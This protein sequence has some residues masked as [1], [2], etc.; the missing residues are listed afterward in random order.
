MN[1]LKHL[2]SAPSQ[3]AVDDIFLLA[4]NHR[5]KPISS[6]ERKGVSELLGITAQEAQDVLSAVHQLIS[7]SMYNSYGAEEVIQRL[8][9]D[10]VDKMKQ[11]VAKIITVH[12]PE[13]GGQVLHSQVSLPRLQE[14]DWRLDLKS[15]SDS[16]HRMNVPTVLVQ[17]KVK[18]TPNRLGEEPTT[19]NIV[20]EM[21]KEALETMLEG[22]GQIR[23]QLSGLQ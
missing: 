18:D 10:L 12:L 3:K 20:F 19:S 13:W 11:L 6:G 21:S 8:P 17:L 1:A 16:M 4:F 2:Q 23:D 5:E 22:L 9:G 15:A 14:L 7:E